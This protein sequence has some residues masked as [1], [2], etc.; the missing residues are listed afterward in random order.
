MAIRSLT[1]LF[2]LLGSVRLAAAG[3]IPD[4]I[5]FQAQITDEST[6]SPRTSDLAPGEIVVQILIG[7]TG[8]QYCVLFQQTNTSQ[9]DTDDKGMI[10]FALTNPP[11]GTLA[12][13]LSSLP[14]VFVSTASID[15]TANQC[16]TSGG[17]NKVW[18]PS[19]M[20]RKIRFSLDSGTNFSAASEIGVMPYAVQAQYLDGY[21][22]TSF[23]HIDG[24]STMEGNLKFKESVGANTVSL[25]APALAGDITLTLPNSDGSADQVLVTDG[26]GNMSWQSVATTIIADGA[27][28]GDKIQ[29][30][31]LT[32]NEIAATSLANSSAA[33]NANKILQL[34]GDG[35][36]GGISAS[37]VGTSLLTLG[38]GTVG[39]PGLGFSGDADT[40]IYSAGA[41]TIGLAINAA[42]KLTLTT[43]GLGVGGITSPTSELDINGAITLRPMAS[44]AATPGR[45]YF[46]TTQE[47]FMVSQD[48]TWIRMVQPRLDPFVGLTTVAPNGA[49]G[50]S[51]NWNSGADGCVD[52]GSNLHVC[53][54]EEISRSLQ[55]GN[56]ASS[57]SIFGETFW[58]GG[59]TL[60]CVN[61]TNNANTGQHGIYWDG[62]KYASTSGLQG[63]ATSTLKVACCRF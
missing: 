50:W 9:V 62:N 25:A 29:T 13:T 55:S 7:D 19:G 41:G 57:N 27:I 51:G 32:T 33:G 20:F 43:T 36:L 46:D 8:G 21:G 30:G 15:D 5:T 2:I 40:G 31:T 18:A 14:D 23:L 12:A 16:V 48:G 3:N 45:I 24:S 61:F 63:C 34:D 10:A 60:N 11:T 58:V 26:S 52:V 35:N 4:F 49:F 22:P 39:A 6:G 47:A 37:S 38:A 59:G 28:A 53:S 44:P 17:A 42:N 54:I 1:I 56:L